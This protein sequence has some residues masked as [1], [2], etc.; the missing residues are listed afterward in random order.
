MIFKKII[1]NNFRPYYSDNKFQE[2]EFSS[3]EKNV[4]LIKAENGT[5]KTTLLEAFKWCFYGKKLNLKN[6]NI[7]V[8]E[9]AFSEISTND[10][11]SVSVEIIFEENGG[12]YKLIRSV[13]RRKSLT[14]TEKEDTQSI[15]LKDINNDESF[16]NNVAQDKIN[17]FLPPELNFFFDG[18]RLTQMETKKEKKNEIINVLGIKAFENAITDLRAVE[19]KYEK[20]IAESN[21]AN[22]LYDE[23]ISDQ[24]KINEELESQKVNLEKK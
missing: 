13:N 24:R 15:I 5:G 21:K 20:K 10:T 16:K 8:N 22:Q 17:E 2:I 9:K 4:T 23:F 14:N 6:P 12:L 18:E 1:L 19:R 3:G 11:I 7:F